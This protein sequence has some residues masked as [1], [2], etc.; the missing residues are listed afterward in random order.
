MNLS[1]HQIKTTHPTTGAAVNFRVND[2]LKNDSGWKM[3]VADLTDDNRKID[4]DKLDSYGDAI[5]NH[6]SKFQA[7]IA[8][9]P[10]EQSEGQLLHDAKVFAVIN[11][12]AQLIG[13]KREAQNSEKIFQLDADGFEAEEI[14]S[15]GHDRELVYRLLGED[16]GEG[17]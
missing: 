11:W 17:W 7:A 13:D 12:T 1:H 8:D 16:D 6:R 15:Y 3:L 4:D 5:R 2:V 10:E 9:N 14:I